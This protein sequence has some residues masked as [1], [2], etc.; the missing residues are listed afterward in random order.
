M[1]VNKELFCVIFRDNIAFVLQGSRI[2]LSVYHIKVRSITR[3]FVLHK[4]GYLMTLLNDFWH[5]QNVGVTQSKK[6]RL[7]SLIYAFLSRN[8]AYKQSLLCSLKQHDLNC[9]CWGKL[10]TFCL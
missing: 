5:P 6:V 3:S 9:P 1:S 2:V 8:G 10:S 7:R 4:F